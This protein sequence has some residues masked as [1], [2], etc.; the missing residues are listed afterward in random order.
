MMVER[1][2]VLVQ[3]VG[4]MTLVGLWAYAVAADKAGCR[5][6]RAVLVDARNTVFRTCPA[7]DGYLRNPAVSQRDFMRR[8]GWSIFP[9]NVEVGGADALMDSLAK[10]VLDKR[11]AEMMQSPRPDVE[12]EKVDDETEERMAKKGKKSGTHKEGKKGTMAKLA[13]GG[14]DLAA[15][16]GSSMF[17][18][19]SPLIG[20]VRKGLSNALGLAE[21]GQLH[22][23]VDG[24]GEKNIDVGG[25]IVSS[26][27]APVAFA[28]ESIKPGMRILQTAP[29]G[30]VIAHGVSYYADITTATTVSTQVGTVKAVNPTSLDAWG[31]ALA[32]DYTLYKFLGWKMHYTH[33]APTS[34]QARVAFT[35]TSNANQNN[36]AIPTFVEMVNRSDFVAGSAYEDFFLDCTTLV[37]DCASNWYYV[38][39]S[40]ASSE[41]NRLT[42]QGSFTVAVDENP[43]TLTP[44]GTVYIE[45][46]IALCQRKSP[47]ESVGLAQTLSRR[48]D[49][50][51]EQCGLLFAAKV[52]EMREKAA[53][54]AT[55]RVL[56]DTPDGFIAK[57]LGPLSPATT[58]GDDGVPARVAP[59]LAKLDS[60]TLPAPTAGQRPGK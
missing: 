29:N 21:R 2:T 37:E 53:I 13:G 44:L 17:P 20:A 5:I 27:A 58:G 32:N 11:K 59:T 36:F 39:S 38:D 33:Y 10:R 51:P 54:A 34:V 48:P 18:A 9:P 23:M 60:R 1:P 42:N 14:L 47:N 49:L 12:P 57:T 25:E 56:D 45:Y 46:I 19:A 6:E 30:D 31:Q 26:A 24:F 40:A 8:L 55:E 35:A 22:P 28:R 41:D 15:T 7:L 3:S 52:R 4:K 43:T 50:T 16:V